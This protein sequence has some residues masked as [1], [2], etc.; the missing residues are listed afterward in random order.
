MGLVLVACTTSAPPALVPLAAPAVPGHATSVAVRIDA[1]GRV[2][3]V[4]SSATDTTERVTVLEEETEG[5]RA[6]AW[7]GD[8]DV[9]VDMPSVATG[10]DGVAAIAL[11][12]GAT[13][14]DGDI[15]LARRAADGSWTEPTRTDV[16]SAAPRAYEPRVLFEPSGAL[17]LAINQGAAARDGYGVAVATA[18]AVDAPLARP[19]DADDVVSTPVFF[20]NSP[21]PVV[22]AHAGAIVTWYQSLGGVLLAF[23]AE[24]ARGQARFVLGDAL[25]VDASA[26]DS[27]GPPDPAMS[28]DGTF[29]VAWGQDDGRGGVS[30]YLAM[31]RPGEAFDRPRSLDDRLSLGDGVARDVVTSVAS[32]DTIRVVW[33]ERIAARERVFLATLAPGA[34]RSDALVEEL[35]APDADADSPAL[36]LAGTDI[37]VVFV[38]RA[39][40]DQ[41]VLRLGDVRETIAEGSDLEAPSIGWENGRLAVAWIA[42]RQPVFAATAH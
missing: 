32:D 20:S 25:S 16:V 28:A 12:V 26:V 33:S 40:T 41:L 7:P 5:L 37:A 15:V 36:A 31:R 6:R 8:L 39:S 35:S 42:G 29:A 10:P 11:R 27:A 14:S 2:L 9:V 24:R 30:V 22:D 18:S 13:G 21:R 38:E 34:A 19:A 1:L 3:A 4:V 17:L 23:Y